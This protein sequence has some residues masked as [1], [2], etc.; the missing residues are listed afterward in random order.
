[1]CNS[2]INTYKKHLPV[3][4]YLHSSFIEPVEIT[5]LQI[6]YPC[7]ICSSRFTIGIYMQFKKN[8]RMNTSIS[9]TQALVRN[10][11]I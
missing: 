2:V 3:D 6:I 5:A 1:M 9:G 11:F 7:E 8:Q 4:I 10:M